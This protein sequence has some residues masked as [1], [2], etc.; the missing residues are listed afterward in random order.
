M[1][2]EIE[3]GV[4]QTKA[5]KVVRANMTPEELVEMIEFYIKSTD[6]IME[7]IGMAQNLNLGEATLTSALLRTREG[8]EKVIA[9]VGIHHNLGSDSHEETSDATL[10]SEDDVL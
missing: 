5:M 8:L 3:D 1:K 9:W 7:G 4:Q 10:D 2:N 6:V